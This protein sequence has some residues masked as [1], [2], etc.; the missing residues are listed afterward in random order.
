V[1]PSEERAFRL[2]IEDADGCQ[3]AVLDASDEAWG[4]MDDDQFLQFDARLIGASPELWEIVRLLAE[5]KDAD[6]PLIQ[7]AIALVTKIEGGAA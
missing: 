6:D 5:R 2:L 1:R 3:V 7:D 4:G